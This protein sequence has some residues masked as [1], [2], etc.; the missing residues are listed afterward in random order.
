[1]SLRDYLL[2][3]KMSGKK[4][5]RLL[6]K[7]QSHM[8]DIING[9]KNPSFKLAIKIETATGGVVHRTNWFPNE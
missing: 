1:M 4:F 8:C 5:A 9:K 6:C 3:Q 2:K 7:S